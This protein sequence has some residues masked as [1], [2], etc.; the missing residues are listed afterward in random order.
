MKTAIIFGGKST[1]YEISC[2][3]AFNVLE[4][5]RGHE[6]FKIGITKDGEWFFTSASNEDIKSGKWTEWDNIP[7]VIDFSAPAFVKNGE[8]MRFDVVFPVL[9]GKNGED[10][11]IQGLLE[12][13]RI[14]YVGAG[15]LSS[16]ICMDKISAN[17][18]FA[19]N[20]IPHV[21]WDYAVKR[22]IEEDVEGVVSRFEKLGY[23]VFIK[24]SNA[25]SSVGITKCRTKKE[26][27]SAIQLSLTVDDRIIA[28][29][30]LLNLREIE[31]SV[32]GNDSS[33]IDCG[34]VGR[35]KSAKE[36]YD[37]DSKYNDPSSSNILPADIGEDLRRKIA[38]IAKR[39]YRACNC[40]GLAR[41][42]FFL[43]GDDKIN[44]N[45]INTLPG[46]TSISMY[47]MAFAK[48]GVSYSEMLD[49]LLN[50]AVKEHSKNE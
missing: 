39:A 50:F 10:G 37:Y 31:V 2:L 42:D 46:F 36:V 6:V 40:K 25:G 29:E 9:H 22:D 15:V 17:I 20:G 4:N 23:P 12:L 41:V 14:P 49:R 38:D 27:F 19:A 34:I 32:M 26:I 16:A 13:L 44:I 8:K 3:S 43:T 24:P 18:F 7:V 28:E 48:K 11:T 33:D 47:P 45:E 1:E 35:V 21:K 5:L 30:G